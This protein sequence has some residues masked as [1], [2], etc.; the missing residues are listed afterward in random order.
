[1]SI[2]TAGRRSTR[3]AKLLT[4]FLWWSGIAVV[5]AAVGTLSFRAVTGRVVFF[6]PGFLVPLI[7]VGL[8]AVWWLR[9]FL[10]DVLADCVFTVVNARRLRSI[11]WLLIATALIKPLLVF[12]GPGLFAGGRLQAAGLIFELQFM[13]PMLVAL[14]TDSYLLAGILLLVIGSAW[15]YGSELQQERDFTV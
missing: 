13:V 1:M 8:L 5:L 7:A 4:D 15:R 2:D 10:R 14:L 3:V 12:I 9:A 11:G 6:L